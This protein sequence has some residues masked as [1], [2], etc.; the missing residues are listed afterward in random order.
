MHILQDSLRSLFRI[1]H[2]VV[3]IL[4]STALEMLPTTTTD[5]L[6]TSRPSLISSSNISIACTSRVCATGTS[7]TITVSLKSL[8]AWKDTNKYVY[9]NNF[10]SFSHCNASLKCTPRYSQNLAIR[11]TA[12]VPC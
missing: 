1:L 5:T 6:K 10:Y 4:Y 12:H 8:P 9:I 3:C 11:A 7:I 2:R